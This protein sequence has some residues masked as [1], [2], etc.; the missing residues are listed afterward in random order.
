MLNMPELPKE[1]AL[2]FCRW[3]KMYESGMSREWVI[4][5]EM[6]GTRREYSGI[7]ARYLGLKRDYIEQNWGAGIEF[8]KIPAKYL[9]TMGLTLFFFRNYTIISPLTQQIYSSNIK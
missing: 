2:E 7:L 3:I 8:P 9:T 5:N 1:S 4:A 6:Q